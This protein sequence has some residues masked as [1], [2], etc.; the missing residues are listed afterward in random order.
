MMTRKALLA[1]V[2]IVVCGSSSRVAGLGSSHMAGIPVD[3]ALA[4]TL[5]GSGYGPCTLVPSTNTRWC[6][7]VCINPGLE[8][9][10]TDCGSVTVNYN[11]V[12]GNQKALQV[13][14]GGWGWCGSYP[15]P[16][17]ITSCGS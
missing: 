3:D 9:I 5:D 7:S 1:L 12:N 16:A 10:W 6:G 4:A 13:S 17:S 15:D 11:D 2:A 8:C 14:C